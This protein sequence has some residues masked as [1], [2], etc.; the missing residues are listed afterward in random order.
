[1]KAVADRYGATEAVVMAFEAG[2][3][4]LLIP[5]SLGEAITAIES[6]VKSGKISEEEIDQRCRKVL[7]AK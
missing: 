5:E 4:I 2:I 3:D 1:M 7:Q 6:R